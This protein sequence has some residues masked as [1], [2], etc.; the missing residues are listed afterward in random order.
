LTIT[1]VIGVSVDE[2]EVAIVWSA[3]NGQLAFG[4]GHDRNGHVC[5][6]YINKDD[7]TKFSGLGRLG[8]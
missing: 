1:S 4:E 7:M 6:P 2:T 5:V 3:F 8:W